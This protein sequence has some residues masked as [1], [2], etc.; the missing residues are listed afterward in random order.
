MM[1]FTYHSNLN[2]KQMYLPPYMVRILCWPQNR[3]LS[4]PIRDPNT[5]D[6]FTGGTDN[7]KQPAWQIKGLTDKQINKIAIYAD[8]FTSANSKLMSPSFKGD[9][10]DLINLWR[11]MLKDPT[12]VIKFAKIQELLDRKKQN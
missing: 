4:E 5:L 12:Q 3:P 10:N 8:E 11:P 1:S 7:E 2:T 9:Y 6:L